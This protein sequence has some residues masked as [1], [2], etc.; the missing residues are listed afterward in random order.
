MSDTDN[1][2][3]WSQPPDAHGA[4]LTT[5]PLPGMETIGVYQIGQKWFFE[6]RGRGTTLLSRPYLTLDDA[7]R[8]AQNAVNTALA[9]AR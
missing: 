8:A 2:L 5:T 3:Q 9:S 4:W 6:A 1:P 7:K